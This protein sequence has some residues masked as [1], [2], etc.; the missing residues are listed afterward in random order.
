M[1]FKERPKT[2]PECGGPVTYGRMTDFGITPYGSGYCYICKDC[3]RFIVTHKNDK[4]TAM[5]T[6]ASADT[7]RLRK[8]CHERF[9]R[10]WSTSWERRSCYLR[11]S[12]AL[13]MK[14][15]DCHFGHMD[16]DQLRKAL[17]VIAEMEA[18]KHSS[19]M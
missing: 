14:K 13:N 12:K 9:D 7:K 2:C 15:E 3:R 16:E 17:E 5:G 1:D 10:L 11:L 8:E 18:K 19:G 6:I 4:R